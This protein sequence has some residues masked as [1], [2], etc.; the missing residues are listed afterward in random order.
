MTRLVCRLTLALGSMVVSGSEDHR[1]GLDM[2]HFDVTES[3][4]LRR[5]NGPA[6]VCNSV[7]GFSTSPDLFT[8]EL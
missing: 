1:R 8:P 5:L 2:P 4:L 6:R 3:A 7:A